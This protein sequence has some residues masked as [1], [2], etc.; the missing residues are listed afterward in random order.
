MFLS[1]PG[2]SGVSVA[3]SSGSPARAWVGQFWALAEGLTVLMDSSSFSI[4][5]RFSLSS[6]ETDYSGSAATLEVEAV[7]ATFSTPPHRRTISPEAYS[8]GLPTV[9]RR[10]ASPVSTQGHFLQA[11][12]CGT[13]VVR[14]RHPHRR[15]RKESGSSPALH[16]GAVTGAPRRPKCCL[17]ESPCLAPS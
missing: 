17:P 7:K 1:T 13:L 5:D 14:P 11:A 3:A 10:R 12:A 4:I 2:P 9:G 16:T 8:R 15:T 6:A